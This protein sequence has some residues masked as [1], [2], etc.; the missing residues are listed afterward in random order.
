MELNIICFQMFQGVSSVHFQFFLMFRDR[1]RINRPK[2]ENKYLKLQ[3]NV[4]YFM[5]I[6][7]RIIGKSSRSMKSEMQKYFPLYPW[8][9]KSSIRERKEKKEI[10]Y[11]SFLVSK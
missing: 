3:N 8:L 9:K 4:A 11:T 5:R 6:Y 10:M 1:T 7:I 2:E